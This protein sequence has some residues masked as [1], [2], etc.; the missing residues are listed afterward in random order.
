MQPLPC[1]IPTGAQRSG[2]TPA[3]AFAFACSSTLH[4]HHNP[5]SSRPKRSAAEGPPH[6]HLL[7]PLLQPSTR[8]HHLASSRPKRSAAEGPP[9]LHL[10]LPVLQPSTRNH[11][12]ASSRPKRSVAEGSPHLHLLLPVLQ[13]STRTTTPRHPD[14]SEAKWRD[15]RI[16]F[17][18]CLFCNPVHATTTLRS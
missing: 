9:H 16:C 1:V 17:C 2:G 12:L 13:P 6:L 10:L 7:L 5:A 3:F 14:R 8:N 18:S 11:H 4:T 15:S